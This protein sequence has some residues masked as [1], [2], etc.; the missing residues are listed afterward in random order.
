VGRGNEK[1]ALNPD[2]VGMERN[3]SFDSLCSLRMTGLGVAGAQGCMKREEDLRFERRGHNP[4][5]ADAPTR[6]GQDG[7]AT[8]KSDKLKLELR[9]KKTGG[10][11]QPGD[12]LILIGRFRAVFRILVI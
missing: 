6:H 5:Q 8:T 4:P 7:H 9:T 12:Y 2:V 10:G 1:E 11:G 3:R